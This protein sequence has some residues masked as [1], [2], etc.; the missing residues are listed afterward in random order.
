MGD[1]C[2]IAQLS[3]YFRHVTVIDLLVLLCLAFLCAISIGTAVLSVVGFSPARG[4]AITT[5]F[6]CLGF[7]NPIGWIVLGV[8]IYTQIRE[9]QRILNLRYLSTAAGRGAYVPVSHTVGTPE[10]SEP[11]RNRRLVS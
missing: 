9:N 8:C 11:A 1:S 5:T 4:M 2:Q 3:R 7:W 10:P 6:L